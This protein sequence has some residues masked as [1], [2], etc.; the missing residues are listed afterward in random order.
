MDLISYRWRV[1][2]LCFI[3][4]MWAPSIISQN[5]FDPPKQVA[6]GFLLFLYSVQVHG[7]AMEKLTRAA[8]CSLFCW[9]VMCHFLL[10]I[11]E[12]KLTIVQA[13][14]LVI[15][16]MTDWLGTWMKLTLIYAYHLEDKVAIHGG[17]NDEIGP[18]YT[19]YRKWRN[20]VMVK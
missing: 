12:E 10:A 19:Y 16:A 3:N 6:A 4:D 15:T 8:A 5:R 17:G 1:S 9:L 7:I 11:I 18:S 20:E 14:K 2:Y 13:M